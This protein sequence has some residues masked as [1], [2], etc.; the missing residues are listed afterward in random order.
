MTLVEICIIIITVFL[1]ITAIFLIIFAMAA[2]KFFKKL[3]KLIH[4]PAEAFSD[5]SDSVK[6]VSGRIR[7]EGEEIIDN[8]KT[9]RHAVGDIANTVKK[10]FKQSSGSIIN[11]LKT[12]IAYL[13][14]R[15]K[16]KDTD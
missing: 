16:E 10:D 12:F 4:K 7:N 9:I 11:L 15:K 2:T 14:K 8:L 1:V 6:S 13:H 3:G 5:I